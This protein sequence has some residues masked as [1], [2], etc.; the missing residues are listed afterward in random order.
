M[1]TASSGLILALASAPLAFA[2]ASAADA[3]PKP[4][5]LTLVA[6]SGKEAGQGYQLRVRVENPNA[7]AIPYIGYTPESFNPPLP[8]ELMSPIYRIELLQDG[9][10]NRPT[11]G[12]CGTGKGAVSLEPRS[13]KSFDLGVPKGDWDAVRV[14]ITWH[15]EGPNPDY[16]P[17]WTPP[18]KKADLAPRSASR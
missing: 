14:G 5:L 17:A 6:G 16:Q 4:P 18:I 7:V 13:V 9:K 2:P 1:R 11:L 10:W 3:P 15:V 8:A 12:F